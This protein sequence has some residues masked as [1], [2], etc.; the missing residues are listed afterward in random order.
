M[1]PVSADLRM[2]QQSLESQL[3][4]ARDLRQLVPSKVGQRLDPFERI[5]REQERRMADALDAIDM[6]LHSQ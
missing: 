5:F 2:A 3:R 4:M 1:T 6:A